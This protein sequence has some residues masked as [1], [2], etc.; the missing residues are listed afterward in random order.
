MHQQPRRSPPA[1]RP[2][3]ARLQPGNGA[4]QQKSLVDRPVPR[5]WVQEHEASAEAERL[6]RLLAD[7]ALVSHLQWSEFSGPEYDRFAEELARYGLAV[8]SAW[9]YNRTIFERLPARNGGVPPL[10]ES[11]WTREDRDELAYETVAIALQKFRDS[12]LVP[13]RWDHTKGATLKTFFIGQCLIRFQNVY[14]A[15]HLEVTQLARHRVVAE[16]DP[17][18]TVDCADVE[19]AAVQRDELIRGLEQLPDDRTRLVLLMVT[20]GYPQAAIAEHLGVGVG[21]VESILSRHRARVRKRQGA[22]NE[23]AS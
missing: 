15:W 22:S 16:I 8:L 5:S 10:P 17:D 21:A 2:G 4:A 20:R 1:T 14:R 11:G 12:V 13:H 3:I 9:M 19:H 6:D 23:R 18:G 7:A